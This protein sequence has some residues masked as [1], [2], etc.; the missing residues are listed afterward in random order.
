MS[1]SEVMAQIK[2]L[3]APEQQKLARMLVEETDWLE[4]ALDAAIAK[5]RLTEPERPAEMLLREH[6]LE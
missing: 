5:A 6:G 3:P 2:D 4:D 1:A